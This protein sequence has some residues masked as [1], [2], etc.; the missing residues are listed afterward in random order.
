MRNYIS[1]IITLLI[2]ATVAATVA[3]FGA[4]SAEKSDLADMVKPENNEKGLLI[5]PTDYRKWVFVGSSLGLS[6]SGEER[7]I[8]KQLFHHIYMQQLD[9]LRKCNWKEM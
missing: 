1:G 5:L 4:V 2:I 9:I 7:E 8:E 6:Y 3:S